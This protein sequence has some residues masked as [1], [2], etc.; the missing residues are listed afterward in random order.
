MQ[1][2]GKLGVT[3]WNFLDYLF[4]KDS[5]STEPQNIESALCAMV[6]IHSSKLGFL[7]PRYCL[8]LMTMPCLY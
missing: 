6:H 7:F 3:L 4:L 5:S 2:M 1:N 8:N